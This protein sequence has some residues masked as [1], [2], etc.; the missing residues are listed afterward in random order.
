MFIR[1]LLRAVAEGDVFGPGYHPSISNAQRRDRGG[2]ITK[3][4]EGVPLHCLED[5]TKNVIWDIAVGCLALSVKVCWL[6]E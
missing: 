1:Y 5:A 3:Q 2:D 6:S 4:E